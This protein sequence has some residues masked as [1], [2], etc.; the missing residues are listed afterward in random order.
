M[1]ESCWIPTQKP[2]SD[3]YVAVR[4][5]E[6]NKSV[7]RGLHRLVYETFYGEIPKNYQIDHLC[8]E[9]SCCNPKHLEAVTQ[10]EN[11]SRSDVWNYHK[12]KTHCAKGHE[13]TP[14]NTYYYNDN[15]SRQCKTCQKV[16]DKNYKLKRRLQN[17]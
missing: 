11:L 7:L 10:I 17:V 6:N 4:T 1:N 16:R 12:S 8:K 15:K 9:P 14:E 13:Y 5:K 3:G 2:K